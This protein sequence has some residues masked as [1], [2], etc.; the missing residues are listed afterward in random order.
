MISTHLKNIGQI[1]SF[2]Q[3]EV[4]IKKHI[5]QTTSVQNDSL[6]VRNQLSRSN[7]HVPIIAWSRTW[8]SSE[9]GIPD[10]TMFPINS[11]TTG[12]MDVQVDGSGW[13]NGYDPGILKW[14]TIANGVIISIYIYI[15]YHLLREPET[16]IESM[17][18]FT[19]L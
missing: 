2:P 14:K 15:T 13:I 19:Y 7:G 17:G 16:A 10:G 9:G 1:G 6:S 4:K 3:V 8:R 18:Y 11:T 12:G 5:F